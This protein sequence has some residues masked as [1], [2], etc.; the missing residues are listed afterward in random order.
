MATQQLIGTDFICLAQHLKTLPAPYREMHD[1]PCV[2]ALM[3]QHQKNLNSL[4]P[5]HHIHEPQRFAG[6]K[7]HFEHTTLRLTS[8]ASIDGL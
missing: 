2:L 7:A 5:T 1:Q 6:W 8:T 4:L 3:I